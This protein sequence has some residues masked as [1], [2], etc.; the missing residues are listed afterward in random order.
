[1]ISDNMTLMWRHYK[2]RGSEG[3]NDEFES[4]YFYFKTI[5]Y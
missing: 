3:T 4:M 2:K 5:F 1:M